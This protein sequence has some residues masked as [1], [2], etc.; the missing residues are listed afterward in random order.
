MPRK[1]FK[2]GQLV[3]IP[4]NFNLRQYRNQWA[5]VINVQ[6]DI[7]EL[8]VLPG[9]IIDCSVDDIGQKRALNSQERYSIMERDGFRCQ[10]CGRDAQD[11]IVLEIDHKT[12]WDRDGKTSL[13]NLWTLCRECNRGKT[14]K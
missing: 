10:L 2:I 5:K 11:Q 7:V 8:E 14:N 9:T 3:R 12:P 6:R 4:S 13:E 1:K